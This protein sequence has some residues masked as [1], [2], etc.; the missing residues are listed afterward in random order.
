MRLGPFYYSTT[1]MTK[2]LDFAILLE[3]NKIFQINS[4]WAQ[5]KIVIESVCATIS[6]I[7]ILSY[8]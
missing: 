1:A 8:M 4:F 3:N 5:T 7:I 2:I 6:I